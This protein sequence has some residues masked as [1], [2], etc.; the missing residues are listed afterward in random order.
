MAAKKADIF[1]SL[2]IVKALLF[3]GGLQHPFSRSAPRLESVDEVDKLLLRDVRAADYRHDFGVLGLGSL[4]PQ[5]GEA[6]LQLVHFFLNLCD[7][8]VDTVKFQGVSLL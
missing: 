6:G 8:S 4:P 5:I 1:L 3:R 2:V 7:F